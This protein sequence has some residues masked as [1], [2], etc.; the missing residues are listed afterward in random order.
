MK[1]TM[2]GHCT[3]L[4]EMGGK[5]II[6]DPWFGM[7]GNLAYERL[8]PPAKTRE[9]V[10]DVNLALV[11]H[12][13]WDHVD[14]RYLQLLGAGQPVVVPTLVKY[15]AKI[16][17]AKT[18]VGISA[19]KS[20]CFGKVVVTAVPA[21]HTTVAIGFVI[22]SENEQVYFSG[23]TYYH[24][25]M[26]KIGLE[27]DLDVALLP[28]TTYCLPMTMGEKSAV[29][30]V[31]ALSPNVVIP[32]HLGLRPRL[33]LLRTDHTPEGFQRRVRKAGLPSRV[34]ILRAGQSWEGLGVSSNEQ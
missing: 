19:G 8:S 5:R 22:Q 14:R 18:T 28:V 33:S 31:E 2:I 27:F 9:Q 17:G 25:F 30:A 26:K 16:L 23:D 1:I 21:L 4:L 24:P 11:S 15:A 32:V 7:W 29:R 10:A 12:H 6:T 13:H 34:V 20:Q 3:V